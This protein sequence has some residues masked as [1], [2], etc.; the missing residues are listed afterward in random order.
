[1][2]ETLWPDVDGLAVAEI[3]SGPAHDSLT[4]AE[5]GASVTAV[6]FCEKGLDAARHIYA[7]KGFDLRCVHADARDLPL[8]D[9]QYDITFNAGVLEHFTDG[10]LQHVIDEMIRITKPGGHVLAFCPNRHNVFY[11][12]HLRRQADHRYE[13]ERAFTADELR[14]RLTARGLPNVQLSGV[15][16][17]PAF[18]YLL[19]RWLPKHHRIEPGMRRA[20]GWFERMDGLH[21]LKSIV[22]QDFVA[23]AQVPRTFSERQSLAGMRGGQASVDARQARSAAA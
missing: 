18:N 1:M 20:F 17:H 22:G 23:W 8:D 9:D 7:A 15:H 19:P 16:V 14:R 10:Q 11:Q 2:L 13:F 21:R 6:D 5:R 4:F 3:G 12:K